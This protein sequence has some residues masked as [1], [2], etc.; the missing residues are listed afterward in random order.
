MKN[1]VLLLI[2]FFICSF[3]EAQSDAGYYYKISGEKVSGFVNYAFG[4]NFIIYKADKYAASEHINIREVSSVVVI[5][6]D[7]KDSVT[8]LTENGHER[9]RYL[10]ELYLATAVTHFYHISGSSYYGGVPTRSNSAPNAP[11]N[12]WSMSRAYRSSY[13]YFTYSDGNTTYRLDK[14]NYIKALSKA[15]A[16]L[17]DLVTR[18]QNKEWKFKHIEDIFNIYRNQTQYKGD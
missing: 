7:S 10:A 14:G 16:D 4:R 17:P 9:K 5:N 11:N 6:G 13:E 2:A 8:V 1:F 15:F 12:G 3:A 18:I